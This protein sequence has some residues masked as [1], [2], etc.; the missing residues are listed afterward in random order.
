MVKYTE[1]FITPCIIMSHFFQQLPSD[2]SPTNSVSDATNHIY[3]SYFYN[4]I[5][6]SSRPHNLFDFWAALFGQ[7]DM[8]F[9]G[10]LEASR[11]D[12]G[13]TLETMPH[14]PPVLWAVPGGQCSTGLLRLLQE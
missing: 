6:F 11:E 2:A 10:V 1:P 8:S 3:C 4:L 5:F 14:A 9:S 7:F 13:S 12:G